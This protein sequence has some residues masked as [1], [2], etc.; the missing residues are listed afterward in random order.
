[1]LTETNDIAFFRKSEYEAASN[2]I[3]KK[4]WLNT[5]KSYLNP[6][7]YKLN[8]GVSLALAQ[9]KISYRCVIAWHFSIQN[10]K[11]LLDF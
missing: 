3:V 5:A 8:Y 9:H 10:R 7:M 6:Q 11:Y 4:C 1:M 2:G